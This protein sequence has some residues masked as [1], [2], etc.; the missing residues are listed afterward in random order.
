MQCGKCVPSVSGIWQ[1]AGL[2]GEPGAPD[3]KRDQPELQEDSFKRRVRLT[4]LHLHIH[5]FIKSFIHSLVHSFT[6]SSSVSCGGGD[7]QPKHHLPEVEAAVT[8]PHASCCVARGRHSHQNVAGEAWTAT[9]TCTRPHARV[10]IHTNLHAHI[11]VHTCTD[12]C[13]HTC[14]HTRTNTHA[15]A[16]THTYM[17]TLIHTHTHGKE[18]SGS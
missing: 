4:R 5:S 13:T 3:R 1:S 6:H 10:H 16:C 2:V 15:H 17:C 11:H 18:M 7:P 14:M 9:H 12:T 8:R